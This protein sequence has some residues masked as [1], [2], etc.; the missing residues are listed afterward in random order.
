MRTWLE[1]GHPVGTTGSVTLPLAPRGR[2]P[3]S[4]DQ[5]PGSSSVRTAGRRKQHVIAAPVRAGA[6]QAGASAG[7][8]A[9]EGRLARGGGR[10]CD[11]GGGGGAGGIMRAGCVGG[12]GRRAGRGGGG[13]RGGGKLSG[14]GERLRYLW[15]VT[16]H[17]R[18]CSVLLPRDR[19]PCNKLVLRVAEGCKDKCRRPLR[20][21]I[22]RK[23][24][25]GGADY[26]PPPPDLRFL[27]AR[28]SR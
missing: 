28:R 26:P 23:Y 14:C 24:L 1:A 2:P 21:F 15:P 22:M 10:G 16:V 8:A 27:R 11:S 13:L 17:G 3:L 7:T 18:A 19:Y 25:P 4:C 9:A 12:F 5:G 6:T 20:S